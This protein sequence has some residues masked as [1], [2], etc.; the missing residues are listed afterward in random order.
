MAEA[1]SAWATR[2]SRFAPWKNAA[3]AKAFRS[4]RRLPYVRTTA[5][6]GSA[7]GMRPYGSRRIS[8]AVARS[9][10]AAFFGSVRHGA[11]GRPDSPRPHGS[12]LRD[13]ISLATIEVRATVNRGAAAARRIL[14]TLSGARRMPQNVPERSLRRRRGFA[15]TVEPPGGPTDAGCHASHPARRRR[16]QPSRRRGFCR[17]AKREAGVDKGRSCAPGLTVHA[18][19]ALPVSARA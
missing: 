6:I 14:P 4:R 9:A 8:G 2:A 10:P 16:R 11:Q 19:N 15:T 3:F 7:T 12:G 13:A 17:V 5:G 18:A 1:V